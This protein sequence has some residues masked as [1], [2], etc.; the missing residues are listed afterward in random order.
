M[1]KYF[2]TSLSSAAYVK[3]TILFSARVLY[4]SYTHTYAIKLQKNFIMSIKFFLTANIRASFKIKD[5]S[6]QRKY[7]NALQ[8]VGL[9]AILANIQTKICFYKPE[10]SQPSNLYE[11]IAILFFQTNFEGLV[12]KKY[13]AVKVKK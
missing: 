11:R 8:V 2:I 7:F 10:K 6:Q 12:T 9:L 4:H 5:S 3:D 1:I 13:N